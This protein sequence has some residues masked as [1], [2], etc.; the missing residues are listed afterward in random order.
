MGFNVPPAEH[1]FALITATTVTSP[2]RDTTS[3]TRPTKQPVVIESNVASTSTS[4]SSRW[5]NTFMLG[6]KALPND[7]SV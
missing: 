1:T 5:H 2:A 3:K 7:S 4:S 6:D